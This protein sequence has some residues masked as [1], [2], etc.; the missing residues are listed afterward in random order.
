MRRT[1]PWPITFCLLFIG[2]ATASQ[3]AIIDT[4]SYPTGPLSVV[5][6]GQWRI[7]NNGTNDAQ[8]INQG[9]PANSVLFDNTYGDVVAYSPDDLLAGG[10][11]TV[12]LDFF[13]PSITNYMGEVVAIGSGD[14]AANSMHYG[15]GGEIAGIMVG[16]ARND[17]GVDINL[18]G[19]H[20][21]TFP[22]VT[23]VSPDEW[24]R[25]GVLVLASG[26]FTMSVD[27]VPV[28][29]TYGFP[30]LT[31]PLGFNAIELY[32]AHIPSQPEGVSY[33]LLDNIALEGSAIPEPAT[34][35]L[36]GSALAG[37]AVFGLKRRRR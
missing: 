36:L 1:F 32:S 31:D 13:V 8:V 6:G 28:G 11:A 19:T 9:N 30:V 4:F 37:L 7:W 18:W 10:S 14:P 5:S 2:I 3:A 21:G 26:S 20:L 22:L 29:G 24:H 15:V 33:F 23:T 25:L 16:Y 27:G 35:L 17:D 34:A 12:A